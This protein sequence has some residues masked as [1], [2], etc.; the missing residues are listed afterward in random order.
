[1]EE[2]KCITR[3][4]NGNIIE[5]IIKLLNKEPCFI[6]VSKKLVKKLKKEYFRERHFFSDEF[7]N[8]E[9]EDTYIWIN[10]R[11]TKWRNVIL[12]CE[13]GNELEHRN[14]DPKTIYFLK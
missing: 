8:N 7:R 13:N 11:K 2:I 1:M 5:E 4:V 10:N 14:E 12:G 3:D 9:K 6:Y